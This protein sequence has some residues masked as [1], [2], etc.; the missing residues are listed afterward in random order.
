MRKERKHYTAEEKVAILRRH[1]LDKVPVS[2]L[3]EENGLQLPPDLFGARGP[4]VELEDPGNPEAVA[5]AHISDFSARSSFLVFLRL[6]GG[7]KATFDYLQTLWDFPG[8]GSLLR[9]MPII[10]R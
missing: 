10:R 1:L 9:Q 2:D 6:P 8:P 5:F 3:C 7:R 4:W